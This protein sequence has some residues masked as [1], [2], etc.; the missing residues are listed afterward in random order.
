MDIHEYQAKALFQK[1]GITTLKS[2][3]VDSSSVS[4]S[5]EDSSSWMVKAQIHAGG[6]GLA[7]GIK[8]APDFKTAQSMAQK[9]LGQKLVTAQTGPEGKTIHQVLIEKAVQIE[10]E[11]YLSF[12]LDRALQKIILI[13]SSEGGVSIEE[14]AHK[15]EDKIKK[16]VLDT[17]LGVLPFHVWNILKMAGLNS[18]AFK[19]L[20]SFLDSLYKL[21]REKEAVLIEINPLAWTKEGVFL[22]L[23]AK[24]SIDDNSLFR[25]EELKSFMDLKAL[26]PEERKAKQEDLSFVKVGGNIGCLV[27][28]AGLAMATMDIVQLKGAEPA[29]FLDVGGGVD[30]EKIDTAFQ[31]LKED[32]AVKGVLINIFGGIVKCDLIAEGLV[33]AMKSI[34]TPVVVRLEGTHADKAQEILKKSGLKIF[35]E[36]DLDKAT[37]KIISL[38]K[39]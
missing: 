4:V 16:F 21:M 20:K 32:P 36:K 19:A 3:V 27:N 12:V 34:N 33:K 39:G 13:V 37:E 9:M 15:E 7:G 18:S 35:L 5:D 8:K 31:I 14:T 26:P 17:H 1:F 23:D 38:I 11:L 2:Y 30:S 24:V 6:R 10:K 25:Q 29:N 28:G 22:P